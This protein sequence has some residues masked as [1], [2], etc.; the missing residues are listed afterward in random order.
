[1]QEQP[2][3]GN[4]DRC[5][6]RLAADHPHSRAPTPL[7]RGP[8]HDNNRCANEGANAD[9]NADADAPPLFRRSRLRQRNKRRAPPRASALSAGGPEHH[10]PTARICLLPSIESAGRE[11]EP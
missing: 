8:T 6:R 3:E 9:A 10:L 1:V 11:P 4:N 2:H 7:A 5:E